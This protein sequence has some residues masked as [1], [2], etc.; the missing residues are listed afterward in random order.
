MPAISLERLS[1][2][3]HVWELILY[4]QILFKHHASHRLYYLQKMHDGLNVVGWTAT[5][6][7]VASPLRIR[8]QKKLVTYMSRA[9]AKYETSYL[10]LIKFCRFA[11]NWHLFFLLSS[12]FE[13]YHLIFH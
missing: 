9:G 8:I 10:K 5:Q 2:D 12:S 1:S 11:F 4:P 13:I 6:K 7:L 3:A